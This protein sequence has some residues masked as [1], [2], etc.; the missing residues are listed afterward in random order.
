MH[1]LW[2][3]KLWKS[4]FGSSFSRKRNGCVTIDAPARKAIQLSSVQ[5]SFTAR[6]P[7]YPPV[8]TGSSLASPLPNPPCA[9]TSPTAEP[10]AEAQHE[11]SADVAHRRA[12]D[13]GQLARPLLPEDRLA[14]GADAAR[15][16]AD[17]L[18]LREV[19]ERV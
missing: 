5:C 12:R 6:V 18:Q 8:T 14:G 2:C 7:S 4:D 19:A 16:I 15:A 10:A 1:W 13:D 3:M 9:A 17:A 11:A